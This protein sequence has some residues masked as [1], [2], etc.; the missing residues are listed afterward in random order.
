MFLFLCS[1]GCNLAQEIFVY[2][3]CQ[4]FFLNEGN[5][6][7]GEAQRTSIMDSVLGAYLSSSSHHLFD[8]PNAMTISVFKTIFIGV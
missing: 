4:C 6:C 1:D 2:Q 3:T 8:L 7:S 5:H